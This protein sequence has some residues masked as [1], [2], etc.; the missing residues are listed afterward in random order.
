MRRN[1]SIGFLALAAA[2]LTSQ[3]VAAKPPTADVNVVNTP[4]VNVANTAANAVP[5]TIA[6]PLQV[7]PAEIPFSF[8]D[9]GS[10]NTTNCFFEFPE[11]PAGKMLA[12]KFVS[13]QVRPG[14]GSTATPAF[15]ELVTSNTEDPS[16]GVR[17]VFGLTR[18]GLTGSSVVSDTYAASAPILAFVRAG[19]SARITVLSNTSGSFLFSQ[20]TIS[21]H[22]IAAP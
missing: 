2:C 22:L 9:V 3:V 6:A 5:V 21:G 16:I 17:A 12:I 1:Q 11:V 18:I 19:R 10:C 7:A 8:D 15:A 4:S 14:S 20:A 13:V